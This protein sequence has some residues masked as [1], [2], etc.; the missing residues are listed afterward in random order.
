[1][2]ETVCFTDFSGAPALQPSLSSSPP[3]SKAPPRTPAGR[4]GSAAHRTT[5][6]SHAHR[7]HRSATVR[8]PGSVAR[9]RARPPPALASSIARAEECVPSH[10]TIWLP[11]LSAAQLAA[12][13]EERRLG[14]SQTARQTPWD[15]RLASAC[16]MRHAHAGM[17]MCCWHAGPCC[18]RCAVRNGPVVCIMQARHASCHTPCSP[19][20]HAAVAKW[21]H[22]PCLSI[23]L[24]CSIRAYKAVDGGAGEPKSASPHLSPAPETLSH[25]LARCAFF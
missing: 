16:V 14:L 23:T 24:S 7:A 20:N 4:R 25:L 5:A 15:A 12:P 21:H 9:T 10:I 8:M 2:R 19:C 6:V 18:N 1:M 13:V 22:A 3:T 11:P 17:R